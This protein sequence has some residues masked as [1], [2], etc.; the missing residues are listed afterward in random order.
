M[1][2]PISNLTAAAA[3]PD[4]QFFSFGRLTLLF[5]KKLAENWRTLLLSCAGLLAFLAVFG[6]IFA[7]ESYDEGLQP[8]FYSSHCAKLFTTF[9][10][11]VFFIAG[12]YVASIS[13]GS[14]AGG[15][16]TLGTLMAPASQFEKYLMRW[17]VAVPLFILL[18]FFFAFIADWIRV[19][20]AELRFEIDVRP[21]PW[22]KLAF[23]PDDAG[24][25]DGA[26]DFV[27]MMF[28]C[29]QSFFFLGAIVWPKRSM[30]KTFVT[31]AAVSFI[32]FWVMFWIVE[33]FKPDSPCY[34]AVPAIRE[35]LDDPRIITGLADILLAIVALFNYWLTYRRFREAE[36]INRW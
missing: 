12:A 7:N 8:E 1:T 30:V 22:L 20:Y 23:R 36:I 2:T 28:V 17:L 10:I 4:S 35:E 15:A 24:Y 25:F 32:Y 26:S 19:C 33:T 31:V 5:Q 13:F 3:A 21:I 11:M 27:M 29:M 9:I 6:I 18:F 16:P 14:M 34:Y